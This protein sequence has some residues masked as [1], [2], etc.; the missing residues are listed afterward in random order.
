MYVAKKPVITAVRKTPTVES[1]TPGQTIG[2][3]S[4]QLVSNPPEKIMKMR[5]IMPMDLAIRGLSKYI[6]PNPSDPERTPI[7]RN[8]SRTGIANL[9]EILLEMTLTNINI[10]THNRTISIDTIAAFHGPRLYTIK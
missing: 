9:S 5:A 4:S 10:A 6:P 1:T 7:A 8:K 3:V 2:R